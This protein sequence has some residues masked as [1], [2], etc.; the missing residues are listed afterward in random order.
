MKKTLAAKFFFCAWLIAAPAFASGIPVF[1]GANVTQ[2][3]MTAIESMM[4][5]LKQI[6]QYNTQLRQLEDQIRNTTAPA[7]YLWAQADSTMRQIQGLQYRMM[8]LYEQAGNP[9]A[10]LARFKDAGYYRGAG[11]SSLPLSASPQE[12]AKRRDLA[13]EGSRAG[14]EMQKKAYDDYARTWHSTQDK[15]RDNAA[16]LNDLQARAQTAGG[17]ME[18]IQYTNQL[19]AMQIEMMIQLQASLQAMHAAN[20]ARGQTEADERARGEAAADA[21]LN[22]TPV[23]TPAVFPHLRQQ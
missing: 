3:T 2:T 13:S 20:V 17:R 7:M 19:S 4:Q 15:L 21:A 16:R 10:L 9:E 11:S 12:R 5:T 1:D 18:A 22:Y 6:E 23:K 14:T 8:D